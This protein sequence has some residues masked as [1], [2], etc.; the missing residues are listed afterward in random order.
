MTRTDVTREKE[1]EGLLS[2]LGA[3]RDRLADAN[4]RFKAAAS[5]ERDAEAFCEKIRSDLRSHRIA[6][7]VSQKE[8][9]GRLEL[10]QSAISKI[11]SGRGD[12]S[13]K[14]VFR[15]AEAL[16][17]ESAY[18]F[19]PVAQA[20]SESP[21]PAA[22]AEPE[23]GPNAPPRH[24]ADAP[25]AA[26]RIA[27]ESYG[28]LVAYLAA[29][30]RDVPAAEDAL[31]DAFAAAL[32]HWP[33]EGVPP[34]PERW[35]ATAAR[36]HLIEAGRRSA[37]GAQTSMTPE[38]KLLRAIFGET[39]EEH[40]AAMEAADMAAAVASAVQEDLV[41]RVPGIVHEAFARFAARQERVTPQSRTIP[42]T[43]PASRHAGRTARKPA[44]AR[45]RG[46]ETDAAEN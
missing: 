10:G 34:N 15:L 40:P 9:A 5:I 16:G 31:A 21:R 33:H 36:R 13:L 32:A 44:R 18:A 42:A 43:A 28:K 29:A 38:E 11:E 22:R 45:N 17:L 35:L 2:Q 1:N 14:M 26:A 27:R 7:G 8:L 23:R 41:D 12:L 4:P 30:S 20:R 3:L 46:E 25:A 39:S 6:L 19:G 24:D 37:E